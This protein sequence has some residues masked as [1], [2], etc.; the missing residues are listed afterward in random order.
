MTMDGLERFLSA[1]EGIYGTALADPGK[2]GQT[3]TLGMSRSMLNFS[4]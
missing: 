1:Q 2:I 4:E 3:G